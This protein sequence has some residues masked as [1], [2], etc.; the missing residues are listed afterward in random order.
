M[1]QLDKTSLYHS[2]LDNLLIVG[3]FPRNLL[4]HKPITSTNILLNLHELNKIQLNHLNK[5]HKHHSRQSKKC[6]CF[7]LQ[8]YLMENEKFINKNDMEHIHI[9]I[10]N[11]V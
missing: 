1:T 10:I 4:L 11:H 5:Y 9:L 6:K 8:Q 3:S 2:I 7:I